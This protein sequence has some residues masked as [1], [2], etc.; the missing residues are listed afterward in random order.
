MDIYEVIKEKNIDFPGKPIPAGNYSLA[1]KA[2][3]FV[4]TSGQ[5]PKKNGVLIAKG[6]IGEVITPEDGYMLAR[7]ATLNALAA[8]ESVIEDLNKIEKIVKVT[9]F[10]N[11]AP[12][13][14]G[15]VQAAN[16]VTDLLVDMFGIENGRPARSAVGVAELP[17]DAPCEVELIALLKK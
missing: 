9:V 13:F 11:S 3:D 8:I 5:T 15:Q 16:G 2:G 12:G 10:V 6:K 1:V 17:G 7:R 4:F 14:T